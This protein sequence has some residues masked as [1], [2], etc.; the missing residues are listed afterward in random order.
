MQLSLARLILARQVPCNPPL[1]LPL[2]LPV[3]LPLAAPVL[4][5]MLVPVTVAGWGI[6]EAAAAALWGFVGLTPED[7]AT[8]SVTYGAIALTSA[9]PGVL[10]LTLPSG[11]R[12]R[13]ARPGR[14]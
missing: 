13:R 11:G 6:R 5:T 7:G 3:L 4:M 8:I 12:S 1:L 2:P 10:A 9:L 14:E